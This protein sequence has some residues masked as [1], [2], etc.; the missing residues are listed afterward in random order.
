M[1]TEEKLQHFYDVAM[2][3]AREE[4]QNA[5]EDYRAALSRML[6]EHK[7]EKQKNAAVQLKLETENARR[8]INKALSAEQ[9]H[10]KRRL[11]RKQQELREKLFMEVKDKLEAF[12]GS[13]N[14]LNW[15][16]EKICEALKIAGEDEVHIY[17][18]PADSSLLEALCARCHT[19][20]QISEI[21]FMG[22]IKAVIPA[23]NIL[24]DYTFKTLYENEKEEFNFDGGLLHE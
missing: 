16:E 7:E 20:V 9:L 1:T 14:Y 23:K 17:L 2:E 19:A 13:P 3:S 22:G 12:M 6:A 10:I 24:I 8:E 11:S 18:T 4:S 21:P 15:L 5:L